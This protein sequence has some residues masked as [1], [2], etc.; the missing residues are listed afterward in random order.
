MSDKNIRAHVFISFQNKLTYADKII[1]LGHFN[2]DLKEWADALAEY[3]YSVGL[4]MTED[5]DNDGTEEGENGN[6]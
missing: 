6:S 2:H 3:A 1:R 4:E 5:A